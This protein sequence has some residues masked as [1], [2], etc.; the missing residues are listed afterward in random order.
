M[1][2]GTNNLIMIASSPMPRWGMAT[3][4]E[5]TGQAS[6]FCDNVK[7]DCQ[8]L[9]SIYC[10]Y[11]ICHIIGAFEHLFCAAVY[12]MY[13]IFHIIGAFEH[14]LCPAIHCMYFIL[15]RSSQCESQYHLIETKRQTWFF[16]SGGGEKSE[17]LSVGL[18]TDITLRLFKLPSLEMVAK[19][20]L[21]GGKCK[22]V[23]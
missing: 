14:L 15:S 3:P 20:P 18:W 9:K 6:S 11:Y 16:C 10:M 17:V 21:G 4:P 1:I 7:K 23:G 5:E 12:C 19:E 8:W 2:P 13:C 22:F